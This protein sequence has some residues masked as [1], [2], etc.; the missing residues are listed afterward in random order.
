MFVVLICALSCT[1][2]KKKYHLIN[3]RDEFNNIKVIKTSSKYDAL[4]LN[5]SLVIG[6]ES[7]LIYR[8]YKPNWLFTKVN[9]TQILDTNNVITPRINDLE[10]PFEISKSKKTN[11]VII[12]KNKDTLRFYLTSPENFSIIQGFL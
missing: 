2:T 7:Q 9:N 5:D 10:C 12:I 4:I 8:D 1:Q 6:I 3:F 11:S